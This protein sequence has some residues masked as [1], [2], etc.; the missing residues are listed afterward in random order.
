MDKT[1]IDRA[2]H[3]SVAK[4][5]FYLEQIPTSRL[6]DFPTAIQTLAGSRLVVH[7]PKLSPLYYYNTCYT[8]KL[9]IVK[10]NNFLK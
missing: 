1:L 7:V 5:L 2:D 4:G 3:F 10:L 6:I 9:K 8:R